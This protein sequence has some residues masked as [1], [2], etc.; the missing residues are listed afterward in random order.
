M[1]DG[2]SFFS[3]LLFFLCSFLGILLLKALRK[4]EALSRSVD[5][6]ANEMKNLTKNFDS[7]SSQLRTAK[8]ELEIVSHDL[9]TT[10]QALTA[11]RLETQSLDS[12][13]KRLSKFSEVADAHDEAER[14]KSTAQAEVEAARDQAKKEVKAAKDQAHRLIE[15]AKSKTIALLKEANEQAV[16]IA[17]DAL[18]VRNDARKYENIVAAMKNRIEGYGNAYIVPSTSLLDDLAEA[19]GFAEAGV[20]LKKARE[21]ARKMVKGREAADCD[22]VEANRKTT[23]VDFVVDAFNGKVDSILS[24]VKHDNVGTLTQEIK[25]AFTL[26]NHN[27]A[28]FRQAR[29]TQ[30]YLKV[31]LEEL[32]WAAIVQEIKLRDQEE[33]RR[34]RE[35]IREEEK[36]RKEFERAM[37][38]AEKEE[39]SIKKAIDRVLRDTEKATAEQRAQYE[40]QL[41]LL[42]EKLRVAEEKNQRAL[43]MAQQT[44]AGHVYVISNVGSFGEQVLKIGMTRRLEPLDRVR[45][46]GDASVPFPFDV[47]AMIY[48]E[49]A[50]SLEKSLHTHFIKE[51]VNKINPRK[52]FFRADIKW[53]REAIENLGVNASWTMTAEAREYRESLA[54]EKA[55]VENPAAAQEWARHQ[56]EVIEH[57]DVQD[58]E[59]EPSSTPMKTP[60]A[61]RPRGRLAAQSSV[62]V[63]L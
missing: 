41:A 32:K 25:D 10:S 7:A 14:L 34:I 18:A 38:E 63:G 20:E 29:I 46:L 47:H 13:V 11:S 40:S 39:E 55:I 60:V 31:R 36:A 37:K 15:D 56:E 12:E 6:H 4:N 28:A 23:A 24:R 43:S 49:D 50:P 1:S 5:N 22:Y 21:R 19:Y 48:S 9:S 17:G 51:Q 8:N 30:S 27:G 45:E 42:T 59:E 54:L 52:E 33:Q 2:G 16:F 44:R 62:Q 61:A 35:Q 58:E 57:A 3:V 53:I 26:V